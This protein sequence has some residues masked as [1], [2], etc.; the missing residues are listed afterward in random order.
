MEQDRPV[1][2]VTLTHL[3]SVPGFSP[4]RIELINR[5]LGLNA[6]V[7]ARQCGFRKQAAPIEQAEPA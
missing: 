5:A 2:I 4:K 3:E 7:T 1:I 6:S